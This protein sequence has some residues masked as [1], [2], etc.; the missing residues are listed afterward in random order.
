MEEKV[1]LNWA[2]FGDH[3]NDLFY[4]LYS[5][6]KFADVTLICDD[7]TTLK[8]HKFVLIT[9][10]T[11]FRT[12]ISNDSNLS[13]VYLRGV[14]SKEMDAI[15]QF[16]YLGEVSLDRSELKDVL[17]V[18]DDLEIEQ[19][20]NLPEF[21]DCNKIAREDIELALSKDSTEES[22][23]N[24]EDNGKDI[25]KLGT[26]VEE[27]SYVNHSM[28]GYWGL[29]REGMMY[30]CNYCPQEESN[31]VDLKRHI[32]EVHDEKKYPL[33]CPLCGYKANLSNLLSQHVQAAHNGRKHPCKECDY[34][35][36]SKGNLKQ[37]IEI[38]H[39]KIKYNC[40][41]CNYQATKIQRVSI[42]TKLKHPEKCNFN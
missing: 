3:A 4:D 16:I 11:V 23:T 15:L 32:Q 5:T 24:L 25:L 42:H 41:F 33:K 35:S 12:I 30:P 7:N 22:P 29:K 6:Q 19:M 10:S 18:A 36:T 21:R 37:H 27:V 8:A 34:I 1:Y 14:N 17:D 2:T 31:P 20:R 28:M 26:A 13:S 39:R 38:V 40:Q 9:M